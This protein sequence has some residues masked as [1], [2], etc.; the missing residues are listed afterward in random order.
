[1]KLKRSVL[2]WDIMEHIVVIPYQCLGTTYRSYL[3]RSINPRRKACVDSGG[4]SRSDVMVELYE[5]GSF[6]LLVLAT[7]EQGE[8][9]KEFCSLDLKSFKF[10]DVM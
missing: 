1:M 9:C 3:Q 10:L 6:G 8:Q 4:G 7:Q 5:M 2:F